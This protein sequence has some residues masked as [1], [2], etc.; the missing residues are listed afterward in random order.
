MVPASEPI[1]I[2]PFDGVALLRH[3]ASVMVTIQASAGDSMT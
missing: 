1:A 2:D 3:T